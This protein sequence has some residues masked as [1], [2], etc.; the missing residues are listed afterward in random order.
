MMLLEL[1]L[2]LPDMVAGVKRSHDTG[3]SGLLV[4][5][6]AMPRILTAVI[7]LSY[8]C[9]VDWF[10]PFNIMLISGLALDAC[11]IVFYFFM[12]RPTAT[13]N[14]YGPA[15]LPEKSETWIIMGFGIAGII[16]QRLVL[17]FVRAIMILLLA[18]MMVT[19]FSCSFIDDDDDL[20]KTAAVNVDGTLD[21]DGDYHFSTRILSANY[22]CA[23]LGSTGILIWVID[24]VK[25]ADEVAGDI[26]DDIQEE[27]GSYTREFER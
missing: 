16:W 12:T 4:L 7:A 27:I 25:N 13:D 5:L 26:K 17:I 3:K 11:M 18:L 6:L 20:E 2:F 19:D 10:I 24:L 1:F 14:Q 8:L 21:P 15:E 22:R 23:P 9:I